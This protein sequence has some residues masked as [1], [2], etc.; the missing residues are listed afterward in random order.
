MFGGLTCSGVLLSFSPT[1]M[2]YTIGCLTVAFCAGIGNGA[3]FKLVPYYF[4]KQ[5]GI[6]NGIVS[7]MGG[8][9]GFFPPLILSLVYNITGHY[10]IGFMALAQFSLVSFVIIVW[11]YYFEKLS[12]ETKII[13]SVAQGLMV[14]DKKGI[15]KKINPAFTRVTGYQSNEVIGK[16]P[17]I[18]RSGLH[19]ANFYHKMWESIRVNGYWQG[20]IMNKRKNNEIYSEWLTISAVK[21]EAQEVKYYVGLFSDLTEE[22][23]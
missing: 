18:L 2:L 21:N 6:V 19:N 5:A 11:M 17:N 20:E 7:A 14:T 8:I 4:F 10:A 15:I 12:L 23:K 16:N 13:E 9:G 1:I 3:I 22:K